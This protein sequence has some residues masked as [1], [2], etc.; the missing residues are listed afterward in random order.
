[1]H[2]NRG[3]AV[4]EVPSELL[5]GVWGCPG[6]CGKLLDAHEAEATLHHKPEADFSGRLLQLRDGEVCPLNPLRT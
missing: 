6:K 4:T 5:W 2:R 1:M 3:L